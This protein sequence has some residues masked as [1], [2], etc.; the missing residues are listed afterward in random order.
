MSL[1]RV[2]TLLATCCLIVLSLSDRA[3]AQI[4]RRIVRGAILRAPL[5]RVNSGPY[6]TSVRAP[7]V[8]VN[9]GGTYIGLG[10]RFMAQPRYATPSHHHGAPH[11]HGAQHHHGT[12]HQHGG[13][14]QHG[15]HHAHATGAQRRAVQKASAEGKTPKQADV[16]ALPYPTAGELAGMEDAPLIETL[17]Q[18][19]A[20]L[21]Y[22][23]SLLKTGEGWQKYLVL[24][25]ETLGSPGSPPAAAQFVAIHKILPRYQSVQDDP[26]F[27]K[28]SVLPSFAATLAA[29]QETDRRFGR[30]VET[31]MSL[32]LEE[33]NPAIQKMGPVIEGPGIEDPAFEERLPAI[34]QSG[35]AITGPSNYVEPASLEETI[36]ETPAEN[37]QELQ[38][39]PEPAELPE[40]ASGERS[41]LKRS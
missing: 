32:P 23:L 4:G 2:C 37:S 29:L 35:P 10:A 16:D 24:S 9:P 33:S 7:F 11:Q 39:I 18:M 15:V 6:G 34:E 30:S 38:P 14:H 41:I 8:S 36:E 25:R 3:E 20:R 22:R 40:A 27:V 31:P 17:R 28:I 26:Q 21:H 12:Q 5:V 13:P 1:S 19:M